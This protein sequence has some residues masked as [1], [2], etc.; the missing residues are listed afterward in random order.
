MRLTMR[1]KPN[2]WQGVF[3]Y[4]SIPHSR[5]WRRYSAVTLYYITTALTRRSAGQTVKLRGQGFDSRYFHL[6]NFLKWIR[7]RTGFNG[8][9]EVNSLVTQL[10]VRG[11]V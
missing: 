1:P 8:P 11:S 7:P 5:L 4:Q 6:G 3:N 10:I 9:H 2:L